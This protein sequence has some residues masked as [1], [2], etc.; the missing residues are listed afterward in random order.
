MSA[1]S[2]TRSP[3]ASPESM[4][5]HGTTFGGTPVTITGTGFV[6]GAAVKIG[7]SAATNVV[8]VS[9]TSITAKTP[10][11][12]AGVVNV[13]VTNPDTGS[14]TLTN[15]F[16]YVG[17]KFDPNNDGVIDPADVFYLINYLFLGG[18]PPIGPNGMLSG[19]ANGDLVVDPADI[20]YVVH[21]VFDGGPA[22]LTPQSDPRVAANSA[23]APIAGSITLGD[24]IRRAGG[25]FVPLIVSIPRG[26][27]IPR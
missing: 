3:L 25:T 16:T 6:T 27:A 20:F 24:P 2:T 4:P 11:H 14:G 23:A 15:G 18:P 12:A 1:G 26:A 5:N 7:G 19:D 9:A 8:R 17:Q 22:P 10:V 21:Y 13:V